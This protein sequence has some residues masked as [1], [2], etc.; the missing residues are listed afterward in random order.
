MNCGVTKMEH[1]L[2]DGVD[3][4][5]FHTD[6]RKYG[7]AILLFQADDDVSTAEI[8]KVIGEGANRMQYVNWIP[9]AFEFESL[10]LDRAAVEQ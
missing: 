2:L 5:L 7:L 9:A 3:H 1:L 6:G 10:P 4:F 8:V